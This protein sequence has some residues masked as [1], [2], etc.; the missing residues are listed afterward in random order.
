MGRETPSLTIKQ[1]LLDDSGQ[2]LIE[3][4]L[5]TALIG[6]VGVLAWTNIRAGIGIK[7]SGWGTG[8][9]NVSQCT[10]DPIALGGAC[11]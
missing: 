3:Y 9:Q 8:V 6:L 5:L 10:P 11:P 1:F 7:Y 4:G 2:D